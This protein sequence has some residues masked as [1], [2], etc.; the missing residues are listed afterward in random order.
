[1]VQPRELSLKILY[2]VEKNGA[3]LNIS[4]Q[5]HAESAGVA[6]RD[7]ALVKELT[8]GVLKQKL[9]LDATI[10]RFSS[11]KLK[12]IAP[13]VLCILR[14]G[15]YQLFFMDKIPDSAAVDE[16][17]K[18]ARKYAGKS[19]GFVNAILRKAQAE[20]LLLPEEETPKAL[21]V[22]YSH[23]VEL[24]EWLCE[25]FGIE[26]ARQIMEENNQVPALCIRLNRLK[27]NREALAERLA[28]EG[29][30]TRPGVLSA[31]S[32][33]IE[34]GNLSRLPSYAEG[35]FTVQDQSAQL[36]A[37]ALSPA[38]GD[39]VYDI[40]AAPGGKTTHLAELMNN[41]GKILALDIYEKRLLSVEKTAQRLGISIIETRV[42]DGASVRF[43]EQ[44]DKILVDAPCSGLGVIRRRPDIKYKPELTMFDELVQIQRDILQN[45]AAYVKP[46]GVMVYSTCTIN[47]GEN[48]EQIAA[49]LET[50]K[51]FELLP[52]DYSGITEAAREQLKTGMGTLYPAGDSGDGFFIAKLRRRNSFD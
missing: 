33:L 3:Y 26:K 17:V 44:A 16:S 39:T 34:S 9:A 43:P 32:L 10:A 29:V 45:V 20:G 31:E 40:C 24:V 13:Y 6:G 28:Q 7:A 50:H 22:R 4:F 42:A 19:R 1:M 30:Q 37:L 12:K 35:L 46:G 36:A 15:L 18:L 27:T 41:R 11:V 52:V 49:F 48:E 47:P 23:P 5:N 2:D 8:Y 21:S 38:P 51:E 14:M 25:N